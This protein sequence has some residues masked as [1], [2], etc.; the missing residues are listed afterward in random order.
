[1]PSLKEEFLAHPCMASDIGD[2]AN[3]VSAL[4]HLIQQSSILAHLERGSLLDMSKVSCFVEFGA[5]RG[6]L[7]HCIHRAIQQSTVSGSLGAI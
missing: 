1:M 3:G 7:T 2:P 5:G 6:K 4:K